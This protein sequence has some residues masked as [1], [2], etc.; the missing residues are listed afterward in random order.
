MPEER[1]TTFKYKCQRT[2][3]FQCGNQKDNKILYICEICGQ[4]LHLECS[5]CGY[6]WGELK[7]TDRKTCCV[8]SENI[9]KYY[10]QRHN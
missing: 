1:P 2:E 4:H 9:N 3:P 6:N 5:V 7:L 8:P 10:Q